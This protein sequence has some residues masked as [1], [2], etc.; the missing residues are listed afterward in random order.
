MDAVDTMP[1]DASH[2]VPLRQG[3]YDP[4]NEHDSC[5]LGFIAHI[6]GR[7]SHAIIRP[8]RI[9]CRGTAQAS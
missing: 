7:K 5:G 6:K 9:R 8:S 3:L 4:A 2:Q 1:S